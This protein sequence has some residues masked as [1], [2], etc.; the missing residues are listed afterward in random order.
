MR[1]LDLVG[2]SFVSAALNAERGCIFTQLSYMVSAHQLSF[3]QTR[4]DLASSDVIPSQVSNNA[5]FVILNTGIVAI[6]I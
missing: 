5:F 3:S 1:A 4:L 6:S 2:S